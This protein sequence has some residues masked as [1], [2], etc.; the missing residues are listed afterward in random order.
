MSPDI[1]VHDPHQITI[2]PMCVTVKESN[3]QCIIPAMT[4][5]LSRFSTNGVG[6]TFGVGVEV[7]L[8]VRAGIT[9]AQTENENNAHGISDRMESEQ[10]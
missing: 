6:V 8:F 9:T 1:F 3:K 4:P 5:V 10:G 2:K 7:V